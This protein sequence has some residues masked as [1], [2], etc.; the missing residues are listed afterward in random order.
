[1]ERRTLEGLGFFI[2]C[3]GWWNMTVLRGVTSW[4]LTI[5]IFQGH[6]LEQLWQLVILVDFMFWFLLTPK[7]F[8]QNVAVVET[9]SSLGM[10]PFLRNSD[11]QEW[12][13][14]F[15]LGIPIYKPSWTPLLLG[16]LRHTQV[17]HRSH[18]EIGFLEPQTQWIQSRSQQLFLSFCQWFSGIRAL[19][20]KI[21]TYLMFFHHFAPTEPCLIFGYWFLKYF[22]T[23]ILKFWGRWTRLWPTCLKKNAGAKKPLW[24]STQDVIVENEGSNP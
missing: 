13:V 9:F 16:G 5:G 11:Q 19:N 7:V 17:I 12:F 8:V 14:H 6:E 1:M 10:A 2:T 4:P 23:F 20:L 15:Q 3:L 18:Q 21:L 24:T 22:E